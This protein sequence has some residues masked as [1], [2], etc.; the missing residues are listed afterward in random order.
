[1][2]VQPLK[3][4][5]AIA[6]SLGLSASV[7]GAAGLLMGVILLLLSLTNLISVVVK[8]FPRPVVRGIQLS[9]GLILLSWKP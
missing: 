7:I 2:P 6:I 4:V 5:A 8:L 1:M 3:A 9:V